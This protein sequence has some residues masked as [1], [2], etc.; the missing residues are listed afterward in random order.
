M[1][2]MFYVGLARY[3]IPR[4][5]VPHDELDKGYALPLL[6][7]LCYTIGFW[8]W[9]AL[10][11]SQ[12]IPTDW[13][14]IKARCYIGIG[15]TAFV[16]LASAVTG[17]AL[18]LHA[19]NMSSTAEIFWSFIVAWSLFIAQTPL[20]TQFFKTEYQDSIVSLTKFVMALTQTTIAGWFLKIFWDRAAEV[21]TEQSVMQAAKLKTTSEVEPD[22]IGRERLMRS[23]YEL[24]Q[25]MRKKRN[26][27]IHSIK[28]TAPKKAFADI[29]DLSPAASAFSASIHIKG[30]LKLAGKVIRTF[31]G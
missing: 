9:V 1:E 19:K 26:G 21:I 3:T 13:L 16:G 23:R 22:R 27:I 2:K 20:I 5:M 29:K 17:A 11:N 10:F 15:I 7:A 4:W 14:S 18:K 6:I 30:I 12:D 31:R 8:H 25:R 24:R 28:R